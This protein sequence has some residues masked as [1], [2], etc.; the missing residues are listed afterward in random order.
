MLRIA[1]SG[2]IAVATLSVATVA[3]AGPGPMPM[4]TELDRAKAVFVGKLTE[5]AKDHQE[6]RI[7]WGRAAFEVKEWL[8][9]DRPEHMTA[10]AV[11]DGG[12]DERIPNEIDSYRTGQ[13]GIWMVN[14][15]GEV[16][17][18]NGYFAL[19]DAKQLQKVKDALA[20]QSRR[21][22]SE[23][24]NGLQLSAVRGNYYGTGIF[25]TV[26]NVSTNPMYLPRAAQ[27][28]VTAVARD[29]AGKEYAFGGKSNLGGSDSMPADILRPGELQYLD[30]FVYAFPKDLP[31]GKCTVRATFVSTIAEGLTP[32][33]KP[34]DGQTVKLWTG[35]ATSPA[36]AVDYVKGAGTSPDR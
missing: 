28:L 36:L 35:K 8:K 7:L 33:D 19:V 34:A 12:N 6:G 25:V 17:G 27:A 5:L 2:L 3:H 18:G 4:E 29:Q 22:W 30:E 14:A 11:M 1:F 10:L 31:A 15:A 16:G 13:E 26:R 20:E 9:G 21:K 23:P 32:A 24:V